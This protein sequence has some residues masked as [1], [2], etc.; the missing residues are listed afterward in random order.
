M[1]DRSDAGAVERTAGDDLDI[2]TSAAGDEIWEVPTS[3]PTRYLSHDYFRYIGKFPPQI[4]RH[5]IL[6]Y[7]Q[8]GGFVVDPMCGGG[9]TLIEARLTGRR[10]AGFDVNPV[11]VLVSS[12]VTRAL[13]AEA[14]GE[15]VRVF[16]GALRERLAARGR[17]LAPLPDMHG[18]EKYFDASTLS[19]LAVFFS[20]LREVPTPEH[21]DFLLLGLL[22][23]LRSVSH[24]NVKKMNLELDLG[25]K[26]KRPLL[27]T[28]TAKIHRMLAANNA[29]HGSFV[30]PESMVCRASAGRVDPVRAASADLVVLHPPYLTNTAFSEATELQLAVLGISHLSIWQ[31]E[32]RNRGSFLREPDGLR[33][34]IVG[35]NRILA[36]ARRM[37]RPGGC[38][39]VV[40]GDGQIDYTRIPMAAIT[41]ELASDLGFAVVKRA[42][43]RLHNNTGRTLSRK[44]REE[45]I[46]VLLEEGSGLRSRG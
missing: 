11:S 34:Y 33:K 38:C 2:T 36:E 9:T 14:L 19:A 7:S 25:K 20:L 37:L 15:A 4:V 29:L 6:E 1:S 23:V 44:M 43:H 26:T 17:L 10:S 30:G 12:V 35:W 32:L 22:A 18:H 8:A 46:L 13:P 40:I 39:A 3:A 16:T 27:S 45:H 28:F 42:R 41:A 31:R 24:A 21:R 5:L